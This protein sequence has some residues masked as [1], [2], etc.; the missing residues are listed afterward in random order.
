MPFFSTNQVR[1]ATHELKIITEVHMHITSQILLKQKVC[2]LITTR[3]EQFSLL[4]LFSHPYF[5]LLVTA[6]PYYV[7]CLKPLQYCPVSENYF[8]FLCLY[9]PIFSNSALALSGNLEII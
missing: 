9:F 5:Y 7:K 8:S 4:L 1:A 3:K 6:W 2:V